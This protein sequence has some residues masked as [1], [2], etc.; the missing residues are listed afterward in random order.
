VTTLSGATGAIGNSYTYDSFGN[1]VT[2]TGTS[3]NPFQY[4]GR[5]FDPETGLRYYR[6]RFYDPLIGRFLNED[7]VGFGGGMNFYA[8]AGNDPIDWIDPSGLRM[9]PAECDAL[10]KEIMGKAFSLAKDLAK[11]D[12]ISDGIGGHKM[13]WGT[14]VT[15]QAGHYKEM[16]QYARG[17]MKDAVV[18]WKQCRK[19]DRDNN[20]RL[21]EWVFDKVG[22]YNNAPPP[23]IP[24]TPQTMDDLGIHPDLIGYWRNRPFELPQPQ[25]APLAPAGVQGIVGVLVR[26]LGAL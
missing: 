14:G 2:S 13:H 5:D 17:I 22:E 19:C 8:Y 23:V 4:T 1:L 7:P 24:A 15:T 26:A 18:Y 20:P 10:R 12:P 3:A 16:G 25:G 11:Y 6:A 9:S 21:P